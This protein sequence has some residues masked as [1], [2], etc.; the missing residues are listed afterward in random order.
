MAKENE[1]LGFKDERCNE[2]S[3]LLLLLCADDT[4]LLSNSPTGLQKA[5]SDLCNHCKEWKLQVHS[6]KTKIIVFSKRKPKEPAIFP[7]SNKVV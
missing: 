7:Y 4:I 1:A 6:S 5:L 2:Y 3:I